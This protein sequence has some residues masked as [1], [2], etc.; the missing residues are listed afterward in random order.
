MTEKIDTNRGVPLYRQIKEMLKKGIEEGKYLP[1][2]KIPTASELVEA[3]DV[4]N[5]TVRRAMNDLVSEGYLEGVPGRGTFVAERKEAEKVNRH[6]LIGVLFP[7]KMRNPFFADIYHGIEDTLSSAGYRAM[8][9]TSDYSAEKEG[10]VLSEFHEKGIEGIIMTPVAVNR[11]KSTDKA[12]GELLDEGV[13]V[14]FVDV[15]V[16]GFDVDVVTSDNLRG[17]YMAARHLLDMGHRRIGF[18]VD[19][20]CSSVRD[21]IQGYREAIEEE[22]IPYDDMLVKH[23][24]IGFRNEESGYRNAKELLHSAKPPTAI[25]ASTDSIALGIYKACHEQGLDVPDDISVLGYDDLPYSRSLIPPLSTIHQPKYEMGEK[26]A[27]L[28]LER[29]RGER[30]EARKEI[31]ESELIERSSC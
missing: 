25:M 12:L 29:M 21:R 10:A 7:E 9:T 1:G 13:P 20:D 14:V 2:D 15:N 3:Y 28:L 17:G 27:E 22:G 26:A 31:L 16:P 8:V 18:I 11:T 6:N 4:S 24:Y 30:D 23:S 19:I 5:I